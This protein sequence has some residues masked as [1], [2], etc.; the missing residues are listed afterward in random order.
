MN[1]IAKVNYLT[2]PDVTKQSM[3]LTSNEVRTNRV[4]GKK[5]EGYN[6]KKTEKYIILRINHIYRFF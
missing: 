2:R 6:Q 5:F 1:L 4:S 3:G